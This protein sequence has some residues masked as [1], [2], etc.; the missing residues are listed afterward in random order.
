MTSGTTGS[1]FITRLRASTAI[2]ST[3]RCVCVCVPLA[4]CCR[5][6]LSVAVVAVAVARPCHQA[7]NFLVTSMYSSRY[8]TPPTNKC[9]AKQSK[10][11]ECFLRCLRRRR[12]PSCTVQ[13]VTFHSLCPV[14]P[15]ISIIVTP[16]GK[17]VH[18]LLGVLGC[19]SV[20]RPLTTTT[21]I[22]TNHLSWVSVSDLLPAGGNSLL[23]LLPSHISPAFSR[24]WPACLP[25][26]D[27]FIEP[28]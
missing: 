12:E 28:A 9:K 5:L 23:P 10:S 19:P 22:I 17:K 26:F 15:S 2:R 6:A 4:A 7:C 27:P 13:S 14:S 3:C 25:Y 16:G 1:S 8:T 24:L 18:E 11:R 21:A 20:R